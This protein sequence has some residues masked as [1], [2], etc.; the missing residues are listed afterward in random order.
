MLLRE[1]TARVDCLSE[2]LA[3]KEKEARAAEQGLEDNM[4]QTTGLKTKIIIKYI[5]YYKI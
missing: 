1:T 3:N 4:R 5:K 2:E